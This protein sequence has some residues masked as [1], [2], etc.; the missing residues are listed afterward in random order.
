M[1]GMLLA[2]SAMAATPEVVMD[3]DSIIP[4]VEDRAPYDAVVQSRLNF[5][6]ACYA[7]GLDD[8]PSLGGVLGVE[9]QIDPDGKVTKITLKSTTLRSSEVTQCALE[10][11][12]AKP[13]PKSNAPVVANYHF[14]FDTR[15]ETAKTASA[16]GDAAQPGVSRPGPTT[17]DSN[18]AKSESSSAKTGERH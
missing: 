3:I 15:D 1:L 17:P 16:D 9:L 6:R 5:M 11:L 18:S 10:A 4:G 8:D 13:F 2:T 14:R 12:G 7:I